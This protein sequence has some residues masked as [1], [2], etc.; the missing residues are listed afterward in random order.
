MLR[1]H[2]DMK[3]KD[4]HI[5]SFMQNKK[6][7]RYQH[8]VLYNEGAVIVKAV[9]KDETDDDYIH[10]TKIKGDFGNYILAQVL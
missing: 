5:S 3:R 2:D 8:V 4:R 10:A 9:K 1:E 6:K 7:N